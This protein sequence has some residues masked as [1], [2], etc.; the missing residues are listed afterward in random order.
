[1]PPATARRGFWYARG[2][3]Y[4]VIILDL[5]LPKL[6]GLT[7]LRRLREEK[8]PM[9]VLI[10]TARDAPQDR[11]RGL[12]HGADDYLVK[13]FA[14]GELLAR[15]RALVRRRYGVKEPVLRVADLEVDTIAR[16]VKRGGCQIPL[17][18][19]RVRPAGVTRRTGRPAHFP[20]RDMESSL[21]VQR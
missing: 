16:P 5:M 1:M 17:D 19:T 12:N 9:Y 20:H 3:D 11:V 13:P 10:L 4:D 2:N 7:I 14:F 6:D 18:D 15:V 8:M 21:R